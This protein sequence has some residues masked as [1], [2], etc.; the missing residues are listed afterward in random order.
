MS[1][2]KGFYTMREMLENFGLSPDAATRSDKIKIGV[3]LSRGG[4]TKKQIRIGKKR[5]YVYLPPAKENRGI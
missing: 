4:Y 5:V 1:D 2:S 3:I